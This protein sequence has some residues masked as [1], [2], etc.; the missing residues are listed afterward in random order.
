MQHRCVGREDGIVTLDQ[1]LEM[2]E[3]RRAGQTGSPA[4]FIG[5][6][7]AQCEGPIECLRVDGLKPNPVW[8]WYFQVV[9][10]SVAAVG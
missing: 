4:L 6:L 7:R 10:R 9:L 3:V 1:G 8:R 2:Y 5:F